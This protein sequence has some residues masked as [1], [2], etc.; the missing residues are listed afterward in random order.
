MKLH[1]PLFLIFV[2]HS[3]FTSAQITVNKN[4]GCAPLTG[5]EFSSPTAGDWDFG[6]ETSADDTSNVS[7]TYGYPGIYTVT[8]TDD[9]GDTLDQVTITVFGNP[10]AD[11]LL[12]AILVDVH[13]SQHHLMMHQQ[14]REL[15]QL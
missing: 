7:A 6:N 2:A 15:P 5:I 3:V 11:S 13:L 10:T 1:I 4:S 8:L 12:L 14:Q 9:N